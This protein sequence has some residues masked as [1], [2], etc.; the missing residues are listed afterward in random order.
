MWAPPTHALVCESLVNDSRV[1]T[2]TDGRSER[3]ETRSDWEG[4][5][6]VDTVGGPTG[7]GGPWI[8]PHQV[9]SGVLCHVVSSFTQVLR[10]LFRRPLTASRH[11]SPRWESRELDVRSLPPEPGSVSGD[12][13]ARL[14][15]RRWG[16]RAGVPRPRW[17]D[18]S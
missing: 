5:G 14:A 13:P 11:G 9:L 16:V 4:A 12:L 7:V 6:H 1:D 2:G 18:L 8:L 15:S 17:L 3:E 10:L